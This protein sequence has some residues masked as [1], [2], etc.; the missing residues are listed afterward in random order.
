M[1]RAT[2]VSI[3]IVVEHVLI[4]VTKDYWTDESY[5][6][7]DT[8]T[9]SVPAKTAAPQ[10]AAPS[11]NKEQSRTGS[12]A[13]ESKAGPSRPASGKGAIKKA[14]MG[15]STLAGFFKKK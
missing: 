10:K 3:S 13:S 12:T 15:Q 1:P 6:G 9:D 14:P 8:D 7:S 5:S 11:R 4:P 2:W